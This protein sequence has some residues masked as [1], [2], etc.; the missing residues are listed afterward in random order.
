M[1]LSARI[2][3]I[4]RGGIN[5]LVNCPVEQGSLMSVEIPVSGG[6]LTSTVLAYVVRVQPAPEGEWSVG[7]TFAT[8]L[9]DE[10]L[11]PF[12]ASRLKTQPTDQRSWVRFPCHAKATYEFVQN[13]ESNPRPAQVLNISASGVGLQTDHAVD[14]GRL[15][16]L[17]LCGPNG[18]FSLNILSCV[19][20]V[21]PLLDNAWVLGCNLIRELSNRELKA[22]LN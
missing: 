1:R 11:E 4:S 12:G 18:S 20:R 16:S 15:L 9:Y 7:C 17:E 6:Q 19:V 2:R 14:L 13:A 22:L 5:F 10:D 8:E 21:T 3:D